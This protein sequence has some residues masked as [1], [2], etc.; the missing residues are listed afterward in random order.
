MEAIGRMPANAFA[1]MAALL[2]A[3]AQ[4]Q[5]NRIIQVLEARFGLGEGSHEGMF[6]MSWEMLEE[7]KSAGMIIGSHTRTHALLTNESRETVIE[8][9]ARSRQDLEERLRAKVQH[10]AYPDGRYNAEAA[11]AVA[12]AGYRFAYGTCRHRDPGYPLM[13]IPRKVLWERSSVDSGGRFSPSMMACQM[14][15]VF[16]LGSGCAHDHRKRTPPLAEHSK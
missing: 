6:S 10:F 9:T 8:E 5:A 1:V 16:D 11:E 12:A 4:T 2:D 14:N 15:W 3:A 7:M 13:T